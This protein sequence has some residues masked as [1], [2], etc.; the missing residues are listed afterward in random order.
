MKENRIIIIV[1]VSLFSLTAYLLYESYKNIGI[2][3][4]AVLRSVEEQQNKHKHLAVMYDATR[5]R[6]FLLLTMLVTNDAFKLDDLHQEFG[7]QAR[8]FIKARTAYRQLNI[9]LD[10]INELNALSERAHTNAPLQNKVAELL[11]K[12]LRDDAKDLLFSRSI[13]GQKEITQQ[14]KKLINK[15][16]KEIRSVIQF[17]I[18]N[19]I[20]SKDNF[21]VLAVSFATA[22]LIILFLVYSRLT[23][24]EQRL[25]ENNLEQSQQY[26]Q[27]I[28]QKNEMLSDINLVLI[29]HRKAIDVHSVMSV[30]DVKGN[31][32]EVN[33]KFCEVSGYSEQELI[34]ENHRIINSGNTS[35]KYWQEMYEKVNQG[36]YWRDTVRNQKKNGEYYWVDTSIVPIMNRN[37]QINGFMSIR[38]DVTGMKRIEGDL[39]ET[40]EKS[41]NAVD[42]IAEKNLELQSEV[43]KRAD[44]EKKLSQMALYDS[45]TSLPNRRL[46]ENE[47]RKVISKAKRNNEKAALLF[48]DLDGFKPINDQ[49]GHD[50]GDIVL[51]TTALRIENSLREIDTVGRLGGDEFV[52]ILPNCSSIEEKNE[53]VQRILLATD[54]PIDIDKSSVFIDLSIGSAFYPSDATTYDELLSYADKNMYKDKNAK[55]NL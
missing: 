50:A 1:V 40:I 20:A 28:G 16:K 31:I 47:G 54:A 33:E 25:I 30:T 35:K 49:Y 11:V 2:A 52:V 23:R 39:K 34:G 17:Q 37:D 4:N 46:L 15:S 44:L 45:L 38:I 12:N 7:Y 9:S 19:L 51:V 43:A 24:Q 21:I 6:S 55:K 27:F 10:V 8:Q 22:G 13:S 41:V 36:G 48:I 53:V 18:N 29:A 42:K 14:I 5:E 3:S 32:I 26:A